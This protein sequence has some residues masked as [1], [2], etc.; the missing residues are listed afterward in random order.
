MKRTISMIFLIAFV[1]LTKKIKENV[2]SGALLGKNTHDLTEA[3]KDLLMDVLDKILPSFSLISYQITSGSERLKEKG[4]NETH[5]F[6]LTLTHPSDKLCIVKLVYEGLLENIISDYEAPQSVE[7]V[8]I[9]CVNNLED[10]SYE[11]G[12]ILK[13]L[14]NVEPYTMT[15]EKF[16]D[17]NESD[18]ELESLESYDSSESM[19]NK[20]EIFSDE[21]FKVKK[22]RSQALKDRRGAMTGGFSECTTNSK[23]LIL[24]YLSELM[25][26]KEL[27]FQHLYLENIK[28]CEQQVINM[29]RYRAV[30]EFNHQKCV[31][32][33]V[34]TYNA[35]APKKYDLYL[36]KNYSTSEMKNCA[37]VL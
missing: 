32:S 11:N 30:I 26:K 35:D 23:K 15:E 31:L 29:M 24:N 3:T 16:N 19:E 27:Q 25:Q 28:E 5:T 4:K 7:N 13:H 22:D 33:M 21:L 18:E 12:Q 2:Y 6:F 34:Q 36:E 17:I 37:D 8:L 9:N 10:Y 1:Q 14:P 20:S